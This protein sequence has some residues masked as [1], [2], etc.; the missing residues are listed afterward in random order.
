MIAHCRTTHVCVDL[1]T[2][3][4]TTAS[5]WSSRRVSSSSASDTP[6]TTSDA[7]RITNDI[8]ARCEATRAATTAHYGSKS[9]AWPGRGRHEERA[10]L[11]MIVSSWAA[12]TAPWCRFG[13]H[14]SLSPWP[15]ALPSTISNHTAS[16]GTTMVSISKSWRRASSRTATVSARAGHFQDHNCARQPVPRREFL[17]CGATDYVLVLQ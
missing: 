3:T 10:L 2:A 17:S 5:T 11:L 6:A 7:G 8:S 1:L 4:T 13:D 16:S 14:V 9:A 15:P 12:V